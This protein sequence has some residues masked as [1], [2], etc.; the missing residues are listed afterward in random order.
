MNYTNVGGS[1]DFAR[2]LTPAQAAAKA[3]ERRLKDDL[4]CPIE[5]LGD[6]LTG[7]DLNEAG[8]GEREGEREG[9][10][11]ESRAEKKRRKDMAEMWKAMPRDMNARAGPSTS[12]TASASAVD[13]THG[14]ECTL[15]CCSQVIDLVTD[16]ENE[17][18][19]EDK[20]DKKAEMWS[21]S[22]CTLDNEASAAACVVCG[23]AAPSAKSNKSKNINNKS[24]TGHAKRWTCKFCTLANPE[25]CTHC[26]ACETWRFSHGA[27]IASGL[28]WNQT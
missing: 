25:E 2:G 4:W 17:D 21:C 15:G 28:K 23:S 3:A 22:V 12:N 10:G 5:G 9:Q 11:Q 7:M 20:C 19:D 24:S 18:V 14:P 13:L 27:P 16:S 1:S 26:K 6:V 8:E